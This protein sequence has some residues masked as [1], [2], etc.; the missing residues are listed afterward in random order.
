[1]E[2]VEPGGWRSL[3]AGPG[4]S[5]LEGLTRGL[6]RMLLSCSG[7]EA[8]DGPWPIAVCFGLCLGGHIAFCSSGA[9]LPGL[10]LLGPCHG[11]YHHLDDGR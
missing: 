1:M 6:G 8:V 2:W 7:L 5:G 4:H 10:Y 3:G 9:F 11:I